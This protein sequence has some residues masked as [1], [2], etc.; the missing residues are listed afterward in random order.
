MPD[1][2]FCHVSGVDL[3]KCFVQL[4]N[5]CFT[6]ESS[7]D[8]GAGGTEAGLTTQSKFDERFSNRTISL[9]STVVCTKRRYT[10]IC[11]CKINIQVP[12]ATMTKYKMP[13][14]VVH[15]VE[16]IFLPPLRPVGK[17]VT[18]P[19]VFSTLSPLSFLRLLIVDIFQ[20]VAYEEEEIIE[21]YYELVPSGAAEYGSSCVRTR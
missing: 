9:L 15:E 7:D 5:S 17:V 11:C 3:D 14:F 12:I 16:F 20:M 8:L 2:L 18:P 13:V 1:F 6:L 21:I 10:E 4:N 19:V